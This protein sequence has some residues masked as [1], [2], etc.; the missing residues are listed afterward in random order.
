M[1]LNTNL[2]VLKQNN[3]QRTKNTMLQAFSR[4]ISQVLM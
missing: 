4:T 1:K 2:N 3:K